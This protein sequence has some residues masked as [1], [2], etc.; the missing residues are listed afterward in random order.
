MTGA[1]TPRA[2]S[3]ATA[4]WRD[5]GNWP[6]ERR[7]RSSRSTTSGRGSA[8]CS[9]SPR[10][11]SPERVVGRPVVAVTSVDRTGRVTAVRLS[12]VVDAEGAL[13][14]FA[15]RCSRPA[16]ERFANLA[17]ETALRMS[18]A[19]NRR[20]ID[21][22][23]ACRSP[24]FEF[25]EERVA[26]VTDD[27]RGSDPEVLFPLFEL[28]DFT[29]TNELVA[30]RGERL[31]LVRDR[32]V[33]VD[34]EAGPAE[35]EVLGV[36]EVDADGLVLRSTAFDTHRLDEAYDELD[37]LYVEHGGPDLRPYRHA[38]AARDWD[39]YA[40]LF[41]PSFTFRDERPLGWGLGRSQLDLAGFMEHARSTPEL[42]PD[43]MVTI[44]HVVAHTDT[45]SLLVGHSRG[46]SDGGEFETGGVSL[47]VRDAEQR[48]VYVHLYA[49]EDLDRARERFDRLTLPGSNAAWRAA[50]A[51]EDAINV[52]DRSRLDVLLA[53]GFES[54][55]RRTVGSWNLGSDLLNAVFDIDEREQ[56]VTLLAAR[57]DRLALV[58]NHLRFQRRA[59]RARGDDRPAAHRGRR[60]G[61]RDA[62]HRVR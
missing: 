34:G 51:I 13:A 29:Y 15:L 25:T 46:T 11:A 19:A 62:P 33:F 5:S 16:R 48:L 4:S 26:S 35:V 6:R 59:R 10:V 58:W 3:I 23:R 31:A 32:I 20:D 24:G 8:A 61:T 47:S 36:L 43:E 2:T 57:G 56:E 9:S 55:D 1:S 45:A 21:G 52:G 7:R 44:D 14:D 39:R 41:A 17:W 28:D 22:V 42:V 40:S 54:D 49:L 60:G 12:D 53:P 50:L 30:T 37:R 27:L 38:E 18:A